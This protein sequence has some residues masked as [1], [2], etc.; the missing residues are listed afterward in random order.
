LNDIFQITN[1]CGNASMEILYRS[2]LFE[3]TT[4]LAVT[5]LKWCK[6]G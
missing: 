2:I 3:P 6:Y 1:G 4:G 5:K